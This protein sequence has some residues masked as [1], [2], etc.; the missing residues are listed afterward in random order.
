MQLECYLKELKKIRD[1]NMK[2]EVTGFEQIG[3][4]GHA[5]C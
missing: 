5:Y 4:A 1:L 2:F 3:G